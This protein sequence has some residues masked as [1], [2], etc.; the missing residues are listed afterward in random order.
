MAPVK[1]LSLASASL[2]LLDWGA[3]VLAVSRKSNQQSH[4]NNAPKQT[5][6]TVMNFGELKWAAV[7]EAFSFRG[8]SNKCLELLWCSPSR[9]YKRLSL[10]FLRRR[11]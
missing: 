3:G 9:A 8:R 2:L 11:R 5:V 6:V 10:A 7:A 1:F 4:S